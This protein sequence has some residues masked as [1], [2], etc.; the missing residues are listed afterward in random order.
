MTVTWYRH[1]MAYAE[2]KWPRLAPHSRASLADA[3][4]TV[5]PLLTRETG[6][7][8]RRPPEG[9]VRAALYGHAFNPQQRRSRAPDPGTVGTLAWLERVSLPVSSSAIRTSSGPL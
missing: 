1:A 6:P 2:L 4:A 7:A 5:T 9:T 8:D 3:V